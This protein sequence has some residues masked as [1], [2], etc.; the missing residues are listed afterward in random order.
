MAQH[1]L[2]L[3]AYCYVVNQVVLALGSYY[4]PQL[5]AAVGTTEPAAPSAVVTLLQASGT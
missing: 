2:R 4:P 3:E 5:S 1:I